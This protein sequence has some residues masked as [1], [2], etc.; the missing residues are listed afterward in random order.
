MEV[1]FVPEL[2]EKIQRI[3]AEN[4][5]DPGEVVQEIVKQHLDYDAWYRGMVQQGMDELDRGEFLTD[6]EV[7]V[8]IDKTLKT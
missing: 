1:N 6:E 2:Q 4:H 3:A 5:R 7:W 8:R